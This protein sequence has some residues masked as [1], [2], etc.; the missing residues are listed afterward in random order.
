MFI[1]KLN[2]LII[3]ED[4][5]I[6]EALKMLENTTEKVLVVINDNNKLIGI[7]SD[8]DIRRLLCFDK[9]FDRNIDIIKKENINTH[10]YYE[11]D[12]NKMLCD[13]KNIKK[14]KFIPILDNTKIIG[15]IKN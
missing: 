3:K 4:Q 1:N 10:F 14:Y 15:I 2:K 5:T 8:G 7:L 13:I 12:K 9:N 11:T 6:L